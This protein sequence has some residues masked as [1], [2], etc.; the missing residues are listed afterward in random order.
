M[1]RLNQNNIE[2]KQI[3]VLK[4]FKHLAYLIRNA[5]TNGKMVGNSKI[6]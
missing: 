1:S 2:S 3:N 5:R 6:L 4:Q